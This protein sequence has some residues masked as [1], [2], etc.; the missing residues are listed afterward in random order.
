MVNR[1]PTFSNDTFTLKGPVYDGST[2]AIYC[3]VWCAEQGYASEDALFEVNPEPG[4]SCAFCEKLL[5]VQLFDETAE[6]IAPPPPKEYDGPP[7][8]RD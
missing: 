2:S 7:L 4:D 8:W 6:P 3:D 1:E 5:E